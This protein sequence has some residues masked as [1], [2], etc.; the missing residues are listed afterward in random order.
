MYFVSVT[1]LRVRSVIFLP[2][3]LLANEA[4]VKS[5]RKITGFIAGKELIDKGFTFWTVTIWES[6]EAMKY[7]RNNE[8]HKSAMRNLPH[9]CNEAAY[10]HWT[11]EDDTIPPWPVLHQKLMETGKLTKV[12]FPSGK[13][14]A[15]DYAVPA[16]TKSERPIKKIGT[17]GH[18]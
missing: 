8:P 12:K 3:F 10:V 14:L 16:W 9:W 5:I 18:E 7:F 15:M 17:N 6:G 2:R 13:Q 4:S 1:R 11:Q